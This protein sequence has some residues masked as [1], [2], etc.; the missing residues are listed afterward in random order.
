MEKKTKTGE[1]KLRDN[2]NKKREEITKKT[3]I[4]RSV[5]EERTKN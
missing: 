5:S 1:M 2:E 3:K 4:W